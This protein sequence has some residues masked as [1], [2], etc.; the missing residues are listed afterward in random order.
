MPQIRF[1]NGPARG[2][3]YELS[4]EVVRL[5]REGEIQILDAAASRQHAEVFSVGDM[6]FIRD[7]G[8]RNGT[9]LNDERLAPQDEALLRVGDQI[10]IGSTRLVFEERGAHAKHMPEFTSEEEN[11]GSTVELSLETETKGPAEPETH[12]ASVR[13]SVL[14]DVAKAVSSCY[15]VRALLQK[16]CE[17]TLRATPADAVYVFVHEGGKLVPAAHSRRVERSRLKVST[18]IIKRALQHSRSILVSDVLSDSRFSSADSV[19]MKGVRSVVCAPLLAHKH[20]G[21]VLYLHSGSLENAFTDDHLQLVTGIALQTAVAIEAMRAEE[22]SRRQLMSVFRTLVRAHEQASPTAREG[23]SERVLACAQAICETLNLPV[24]ERRVVE[25][26]ALLHEIGKIG[27]P[28]GAFEREDARFE[29]ASLGA[30]MLRN[31]EGLGEVA[32]AVEAHLERLDG[33]GG[34]RGLVGHQVP[35]AARIVG[36]A[37]E[38]ERRVEAAAA[39]GRK[40]AE[41]VKD[42]LM[43]LNE[44]VGEKFDEEVFGALVRALRGGALVNF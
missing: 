34:P 25:L 35:R 29:Y 38:F 1:K 2:K 23:H 39:K 27:A 8:S 31:I 16:V 21:G 20:L 18:T 11:L 43:S 6:Y 17:I 9:Y 28:E 40:Q 33:S 7:L 32:A 19:V 30:S 42:A 44:E 22:E 12:E 3:V 15:D 10:R 4:S 41:A 13:Y 24:A 26:A 36:L 5:G 37:D 14:C